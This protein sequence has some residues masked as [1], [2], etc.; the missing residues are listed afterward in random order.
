MDYTWDYQ[1]NNLGGLLSYGALSENVYTFKNN[2]AWALI[3]GNWQTG[4]LYLSVTHNGTLIFST[5]W[6]IYI[7]WD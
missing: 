6:P 4:T 3:G 2:L 1:G 5:S 7:A